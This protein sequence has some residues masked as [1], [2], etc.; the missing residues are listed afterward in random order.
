M[1]TSFYTRNGGVSFHLATLSRLRPLRLKCKGSIA[2]FL[3]LPPFRRY[4]LIMLKMMKSCFYEMIELNLIMTRQFVFSEKSRTNLTLE[5][6]WE[7]VNKGGRRSAVQTCSYVVLCV[8]SL[9]VN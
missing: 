2:V 4:S 5:I 9:S 1:K 3:T 7:S 6:K 8:D